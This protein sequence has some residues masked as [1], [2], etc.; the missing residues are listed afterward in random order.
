MDFSRY[1]A[2]SLRR[3]GLVLHATMNRP[4]TMNAIDDQLDQ[5]LMNLLV[6]VIPDPQ[7]HVVVLSGAGAAFSAG[8]DLDAIQGLIDEPRRMFDMIPRAKRLVNHLLDCPK[9]VIAKIK[10]PAVGLGATLA[11]F[12]DLIYAVPDARICDPHVKLG[13]VAGDGGQVIWPQLV[14]YV[15]AKE[16]LLTGDPISGE[17]AARIGLINRAVAAD[18][19]DELVDGIARKLAALPPRALQWTKLSINVGLRQVAAAGL[20]VGI[21]YEA[22]SNATADHRAALEGVRSR[23]K[24]VYTGD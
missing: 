9:P 20:D 3:D 22:L 6:D 21:A 10:G 18:Q 14:G 13:F 16:Y 19:I 4:E 2:L 15:R 23:S 7:T 24:P 17:E 8:G 1:P 5:D 12:C 11:L